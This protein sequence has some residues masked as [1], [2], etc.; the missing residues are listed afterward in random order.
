MKHIKILALLLALVLCFA[1][2]RKNENETDDTMETK[3]TEAVSDSETTE[4]NPDN[5]DQPEAEE[6]FSP[7]LNLTEIDRFE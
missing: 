4:A 2:C 7:D 5:D 3:A 6:T 1:A